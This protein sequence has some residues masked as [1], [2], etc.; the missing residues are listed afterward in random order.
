M[1]NPIPGTPVPTLTKGEVVQVL[2]RLGVRVGEKL[3]D[4]TT[5]NKITL[6][7]AMEMFVPT[8]TDLLKEAA[9]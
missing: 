8:I 6:A 3:D 9:D 2:G 1:G 4:P 7:E 5:P